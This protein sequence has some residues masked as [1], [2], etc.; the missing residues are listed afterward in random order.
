MKKVWGEEDAGGV[1]AEKIFFW[2]RSYW[3]WA[4]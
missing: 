1:L 2:S 4:S 3:L